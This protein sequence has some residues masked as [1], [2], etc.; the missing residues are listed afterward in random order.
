MTSSTWTFETGRRLIGCGVD[1]ERPARF[2]K[3]VGEK[4]PWH[5][6]Y[7]EREVAHVRG[8]PNQAL[9]F[10]AAF[11]CK[12]AVVKAVEDSF[13]FSECEVFYE[14]DGTANLS[15]SSRFSQE[16]GVQAADVRISRPTD[17]EVVAVV[18]LFGEPLD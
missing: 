7:S 18:Y 8:L 2:E 3:L 9:G 11:C 14:P 16:W 5:L 1:A 15:L 10:C 13:P 17:E 12:E 4:T 6:V